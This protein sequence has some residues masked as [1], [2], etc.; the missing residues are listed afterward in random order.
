MLAGKIKYCFD[1]NRVSSARFYT[2]PQSTEFSA[3]RFN[4]IFKLLPKPKKD[5][6]EYILGDI[7]IN[8]HDEYH[9]LSTLLDDLIHTE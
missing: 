9:V 8:N 2:K 4:F 1:S 5:K 3:L 6:R 7:L